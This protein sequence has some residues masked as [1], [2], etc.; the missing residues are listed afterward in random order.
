MSKK[1]EMASIPLTELKKSHNHRSTDA[2]YMCPATSGLEHFMNDDDT[3][4]PSRKQS[5]KMQT[6]LA[7]WNKKILLL[8]SR[9]QFSVR[10]S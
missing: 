7:S 3:Y 8:S 2:T 6:V 10:T 4:Y 5:E 9:L 1:R